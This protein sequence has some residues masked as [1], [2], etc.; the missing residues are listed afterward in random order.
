MQLEKIVEFDAEVFLR[1]INIQ[2]DAEYPNRIAH[3]QPT[4]KSVPLIK[5]L[6]GSEQDRAFFVVAPYGTGKSITATYLLHLVENRSDADETLFAIEDK[7]EVV[8][9]DLSKFSKERRNGKDKGLV[10]V[11]QGY[12]QNLGESLKDAALK[13]MGRLKLGRQA[14]TIASMPCETMDQ[15]I[16]LLGTVQDKAHSAGCDRIVILWDEFGRHIESLIAEGRSAALSEMQLLAESVSRSVAIP[17]TLGLL[18]HQELLQYASHSPASVRAE[19]RKIEG[20]FQTIQYIDDS[21]EIYRL[22]S[23]VV[24]EQN[25]SNILLDEQAKSSALECKQLGLFSDFTVSELQSLLRRAYPLEPTS[26]YLL[27]R[28]SGRVAQNERT[29]FS[30]LNFIDFQNSVRPDHLYEYFSPEMRTDTAVGGTYRQWLETQNALSKLDDGNDL[31]ATALR[32]ASLLGFG[33]NGERSRTSRD[34]L[35]F[36]LRGYACAGGVSN[37]AQQEEEVVAELIDKKLLLHRKHSDEVSVW[38]G[39]DADLR[40]RLEEE[41]S[42]QRRIFDFVTFLMEEDCPPVWR[43]V[44]YN[45]EFHIRRFLQGEYCS[46]EKLDEYLNVP[47]GC[48]GKIIYVIAETA[49]ELQEAEHLTSKYLC[50][51]RVILAVPRVPVPLF[52]T[53][54]EVWCLIHMQGDDKL[55]GSDPMVLSEIQQMTDDARSHL[56]KLLDRLILPSR[57]GPRWFYRGSELQVKSAYDLRD[58]LSKI[59]SKIFRYTPKINNEMIVRHKPTPIVVNARKKLLLGILERSGQENLGI[60]GNF[61]DVSMFRT[62]LLHTGLYY[63]KGVDHWIYASPEQVVDPGLQKVWKKIQQ[64]FTIPLEK[65][66]DIRNLFDELMEPPFGVRAGLL[67]ILFAAGLQAFP[68][69]YALC[70]GGNYVSDILPTVIEQLCREPEKYEFIVLDIDQ[71]K[72][73]YLKAVHGLFGAQARSTHVM[74]QCYSVTGND[75]IRACYDALENWK[76]DLPVGALSTKHLTDQTRRFQIALRQQSDPEQLLFER[77]P[78]ALGYPNHKHHML[79]ESLEKCKS[80][81]SKVVDCYRTEAISS[82]CSALSTNWKFENGYVQKVTRRWALCFPNE[83]SNALNDSVSKGLLSRMRM[84]YPSD[85]KLLDSLSGLLLQKTINRWDDSCIAN[86]DR[87]IHNVVRRI[88]ETALSSEFQV[89]GIAKDRLADLV[90]TRMNGLY[91]RLTDIVGPEK[92]RALFAHILED[93]TGEDLHGDHTR[94]VKQSV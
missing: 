67:P 18:L 72:R 41:K 92:A 30:F 64:F 15:T 32:T 3:Y 43:P 11:L 49:E 51:E 68:Y 5:S 23:E 33:V 53:A 56:Q 59:M 7:L 78:Q 27:P 26:L 47:V 63:S 93:N 55:V 74:K 13:G 14:R 25:R 10:L 46:L 80:E 8:S 38:H 21:K 24:S 29:L 88:E 83:L 35:L 44:R 54:L 58:E 40:G 65:P 1:S 85:A 16:E 17:V 91:G 20:R 28:I 48:D 62:V 84:Q 22:I 75:L 52:E 82:L 90:Q 89:S 73:D 50:D 12:C 45:S 60:T 57:E 69:A 61:P 4:A 37:G 36:A 9:P 86:F 2:Y 94:G 31:A 39:T 34:L 19:W 66:K 87:E 77:I 6:L 71:T 79:L 70:Y 76:T 42:R 81:L